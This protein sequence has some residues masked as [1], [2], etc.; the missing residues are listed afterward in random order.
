MA[1]DTLETHRALHRKHDL[2]IQPN[3]SRRNNHVLD[4]LAKRRRPILRGIGCF[5][6]AGATLTI[7]PGT[8]IKMGT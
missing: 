8:I 6:A 1:Y 7:Q 4:N 5:V 3:S 2:G